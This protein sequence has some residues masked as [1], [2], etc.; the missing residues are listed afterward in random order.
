MLMLQPPGC[1]STYGYVLPGQ[2][3]GKHPAAMTALVRRM[4]KV[5]IPVYVHPSRPR[6]PGVNR[7]DAHGPPRTVRMRNFRTCRTGAGASVR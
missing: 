6:A 5:R 3:A 4:E 7:Q 1:G 2:A